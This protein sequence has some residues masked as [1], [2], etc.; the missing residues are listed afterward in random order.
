MI[1][2]DRTPLAYALI[3]LATIVIAFATRLALEP[4]VG[5]FAP[6]TLFYLAISI[7]ALVC[8]ATFAVI[9]TFIC[10]AVG[11]MYFVLPA[12][13]MAI[14]S[15][16]DAL[17]LFLF[18]ASGLVTSLLGGVLFRAVADERAQRERLA[19]NER[20]FRELSNG[21]PAMVVQ[22]STQGE[23][24]YANRL[25]QKYFDRATLSP[26]DWPSVIHPDD[27]RL[28]GDNWARLQR[29]GILP[30]HSIRF[31]GYDG[32]YRWF[33]VET[34]AQRNEKS[35]TTSYISVINDVDDLVNAKLQLDSAAAELEQRVEQRTGE[36]AE[37]NRLLEV[38]TLEA[39]H[40]AQAKSVFLATMSHEIRTPM[41]GVIGMTSLLSETDLTDDQSEFVE[42]IRTSGE[43]LLVVI[44]DILDYSKI[45][46][47]KIFSRCW[48]PRLRQKVSNLCAALIRRRSIGG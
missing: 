45:E 39:E 25:W 7:T 36:L 13:S 44:N 37:S 18:V 28:S 9:A 8:G 6:F 42:A 4:W 41:N 30:K 48:P 3:T 38:R 35:E 20:N 10:A 2:T 40:A 22:L 12:D 26:G 32:V 21:L 16:G 24:I 43:S 11:Q 19:E 34:F 23:L 29:D 1:R 15:V 47:L 33:S 27:L 46:S 31:R 14:T 17:R 5:N